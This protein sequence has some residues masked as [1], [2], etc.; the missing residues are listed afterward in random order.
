MAVAVNLSAFL[1]CLIPLA[2]QVPLRSL[3]RSSVSLAL[4]RS[5]LLD[6][7]PL[8]CT[9]RHDVRDV[10]LLPQLDT[11]G[12]LEHRVLHRVDLSAVRILVVLLILQV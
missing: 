6:R 2:L 5:S 11:A 10:R 12:A 8:L 1:G 3:A 9:S 7:S 4:V